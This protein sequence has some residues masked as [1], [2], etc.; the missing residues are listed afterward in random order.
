MRRA[1]V[2]LGFLLAAPALALAQAQAPRPS[3]SPPDAAASVKRE[4]VVVV[5]ASKVE[6][7]I[8][9]ARPRSAS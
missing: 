1:L 5:T 2:L 4:E 3:P 8:V 6:S 7:S 9:N